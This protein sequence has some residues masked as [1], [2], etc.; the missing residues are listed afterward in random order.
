MIKHGAAFGWVFQ[1]IPIGREPDMSLV[2]TGKQRVERREAILGARKEKPLLVFDFWNDGD[3]VDGCIAWGRKYAHVP[4]RGHA[5][6]C[7]FV[8]FAKGSPHATSPGGC[9]RP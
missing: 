3:A 6:P 5:E 1:Y 7:G 9:P 8:Q 2:P 4:A